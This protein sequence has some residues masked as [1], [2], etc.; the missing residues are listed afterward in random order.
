[1]RRVPRLALAS[2][3][4]AASAAVTTDAQAIGIASTTYLVT[5][6]PV[7]PAAGASAPDV[8]PE[9]A[10]P[11][12]GAA[13]AAAATRLDARPGVAAVRLLGG[14]VAVATTTLTAAQ[15][16][17]QPGVASVERDV[18][19]QLA[20]APDPAEPGQ[21][22][23]RNTGAR[24]SYGLTGIANADVDATDAWP[25]ST[26]TGIVVAVSDSGV[27]MNHVDLAANIWHNADET[28]GNGLD[29][30]HN[31]YIDDCA[32]WDFGDHDKDPSSSDE[33]G[34]HVAGLI[35]GARN[36][37]G[38]VGLAP[39]A[40]IMPLKI[41]ATKGGAMPLSAGIASIMYA[42]DNGARIVNVSWGLVGPSTAMRTALLYAQ[43][44]GVLVVCAAG[45]N[46]LVLG[47]AMVY[48]PGS[49]A[50]ELNNVINV[51]ASDLSDKMTTFSNRGAVTLTAPGAYLYSSVP[52][53]WTYKSGTSMAAS[54][55]SGAA[56]LVAAADPGLSAA[57]I[58][59]RLVDTVDTPVTLT[60]GGAGRLD[61]ARAVGATRTTSGRTMPSS[62]LMPFENNMLSLQLG[63]AA[64]DDT[65]TMV[66]MK[67]D[68]T[69]FTA[70][71]P[72]GTSSLTVGPTVART[73]YFVVLTASGSAGTATTS[74]VVV[75]QDTPNPPTITSVA[76]TATDVLV[77]LV[78]GPVSGVRLHHFDITVNGTTVSIPGTGRSAVV[79]GL[80]TGTTYGAVAVAVG[81]DGSRG[82]SAATSFTTSEA[83]DA[84]TVT[85]APVIRGATVTVDPLGPGVGRPIITG[86]EVKAGGVTARIA[87]A[88]DGHA[89]GTVTG[90]TGGAVTP[91][92][93][94]VL[95]GQLL[96]QHV[97]AGTVT[98]LVA[99]LPGGAQNA[100]AQVNGSTVAFTWDASTNATGYV[101]KL[102]SS[103]M[104]LGGGA[105]A[106][107]LPTPTRTGSYVATITANGQ[108]G[109]TVVQV[110]VQ[111][112]PIGPG[113]ATN[114]VAAVNGGSMAVT[115]T[116]A[117]GWVTSYEV[118][119][120]TGK[121][122]T[123][124][125]SATSTIVATPLIAGPATVRVTAI[126]PLGRTNA[127]ASATVV[128]TPPSA[129]ANAQG[130]VVASQFRLMWTPT[131]GEWRTGYTI[132]RN[133]VAVLGLPTTASATT[134]S[135]P[136]VA[137]TYTYEIVATNPWGATAAAVSLVV[138]ATPPPVVTNLRASANGSVLVVSWTP[139]AGFLSGYTVTR[140]GPGGSP[141]V[142]N[143]PATSS[144]VSMSLP[145]QGT[146]TFTI[147]ATNPF[148]KSTAT[149]LWTRG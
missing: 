95:H 92:T 94:T 22:H 38:G 127:S 121:I 83:S 51:A 58:R 68:G 31:G 12:V 54:L 48:S 120:G 107:S 60:Q 98:P 89:S 142:I 140:T 25:V 33:H 139:A 91:V 79:R 77:N 41:T 69:A 72:S 119:V 67:P 62:T 126:N 64:A 4:I 65:F 100:A 113:P 141:T 30:D 114:I 93:V 138:A 122:L 147:T 39:D 63:T 44:K 21:W 11:P 124:P 85:L 90:L 7:V 80:T 145:V 57:A 23:L 144:S 118:Q 73:P 6:A 133:G 52:W 81:V 34:T 108:Y 148:G 24:T 97:A 61:A 10:E 130:V 26:G 135:M 129:P 137:G 101:V 76:S 115:W 59:Q 71:G 96:G 112:D 125:A 53:G 45:N 8:A 131:V 123:A 134:L 36:D 15:L 47:G 5:L 55:V 20:S 46:G 74:F 28:C 106:A 19:V 110:P 87:A 29:D 9:A 143:T 42:A 2:L 103:A 132:K 3:L 136:V 70:T 50:S 102:E 99:P 32:G 35:A 88:P 14:G 43:S 84:P 16:A 117:T 17:A 149:V 56:A 37:L 49:Y 13:L 86:Y 116:A 146:H 105:L 40:R 66:A 75:A 109:T 1:M 78:P 128:S 18:S 104:T 111:V 82:R 27:A